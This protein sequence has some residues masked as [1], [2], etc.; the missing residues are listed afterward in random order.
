MEYQNCFICSKWLYGD[1]KACKTCMTAIHSHCFNSI[2]CLS[3]GTPQ[4]APMTRNI[5]LSS[6]QISLF[7]RRKKPIF[8]KVINHATKMNV[9]LFD[10]SKKALDTL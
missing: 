5:C 3:C 1:I 2:T 9:F 10:A 6:Y 8:A 4:K 7:P